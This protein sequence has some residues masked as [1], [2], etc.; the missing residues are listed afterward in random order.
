MTPLTTV[1]EEKYVNC[2]QLCSTLEFSE[3]LFC[4]KTS[5]LVRNELVAVWPQFEE[6]LKVIFQRSTMTMRTY[7]QLTTMVYRYCT[8][9]YQLGFRACVDAVT[10]N[11]QKL[12]GQELLKYLNTEW[13]LF[14]IS[15]SLF[16]AVCGN[17]NRHSIEVN[18]G[19]TDVSLIKNLCMEVWRKNLSD[20]LEEKIIGATL[21]LIHQERTGNSMINNRDIS[22][23]VVCLKKL[24]VKYPEN[25]VKKDKTEDQKLKFYK[26]SFERLFLKTIEIST[27]KKLKS[28]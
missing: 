16:D 10:R 9:T 8:E 21:H 20:V 28:L 15:S 17:F 12:D 22:D 14:E 3:N 23:F 11:C 1:N 5:K 13:E 24:P 4:N 6:A 27:R 25:D 26:E 2:M 18:V 19:K 7:M